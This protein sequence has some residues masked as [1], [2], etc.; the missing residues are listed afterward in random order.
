M[1]ITRKTE[2]KMETFENTETAGESVAKEET[3]TKTEIENKKA[4]L[5][6]TKR[7]EHPRE[8]NSKKEGNR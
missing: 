3:R 6:T 5:L 1:K 4:Q 2:Q 8:L 7:R